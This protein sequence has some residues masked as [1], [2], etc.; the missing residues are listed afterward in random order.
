MKKKNALLSLAAAFLAL[1]GVFL[2]GCSPILESPEIRIIPGG[3]GLLSVSLSGPG[4]SASQSVRTMLALSPEF[5]A[6]ELTIS[7]DP[8]TVTGGATG[9]K[10][11]SSIAGSF[12]IELPAGE[13]TVSAAGYTGDKL[14]AKTGD[15]KAVEIITG[16]QEDIAL[17]LA[18]YM[19]DDVY[20]SLLY[21]LNWDS[22]G[23][24]PAR[25]ELLVER[26]DDSN[27]GWNA[28]PISLI[29][30][31]LTAGP[32]QGT[33]LLVRRETGL[34]QQTGSLTLPPGEYR[35]TTSVTM[36]GP[37]PPVSRTD[38]AHIFSNL[39]TPAAFVYGAG[40][41][42]V[43]GPGTDTGSGFITRFNFAETPGAVSVIGS[44]P[45]PDG[46]RLIMVMV[47]AA[48][49]L[50]HLTPVVEC[51]A[52]AQITSP[53]PLYDPAGTV[54]WPAGDYS[55]PTSW[56][57]EGRNGVTQQ[58]TVVVTEQAAGEGFIT[59]IAFEDVTVTSVV[60]DQANRSITVEVPNGTLAAHSNYELKPVISFTGSQ[61]TVVDPDYLN[62]PA[63][64]SPFTQGDP[65]E[66]IENGIP[67]R[68]FRVTGQNGET[69]AYTVMIL[70]ALS[71]DAEITRFFFDG[72]PDCPVTL[73]QPSGSPY[74]DGTIFVTLPYASNLSSLKPLITYKGKIEPA[75]GMEQNFNVPVK[76]I[77]T[78]EDRS[79]AKTYTV[80][81]NTEAANT[82]T[83]I[84]DFVITNVPRAKVVIGTKPRADGKI[85]IVVSVPY[86]TAPLITPTPDD[87]P[88]TDL[89]ALIPKITL[90]SSDSK[91]V[92]SG[93]SDMSPPNGTTD[94]IPFGNSNDDYQEA[95]YRI[96]AQAGNIQDYVVVAA[97]DVHYYYV[98]ATGDDTDPDQYNGG[99]ES[100]PFK[101]LAYA[102]YQA[103][104]HNVDH[105]YVIGTLNDASEGG[106]WENTASTAMGGSGDFHQSGAPSVAGG[107]SVFNLNGAGRDGAA[108]WRLS[109]TGVGSN[110]VLQGA[111]GKRVIAVTGG[112]H[113]T[114]ENITIRGGGGTA[115][116]K[117]GGMYIGGG[118]TVI[119][120]S[121]GIT[122]NK[123]LSGG[124]VY[125]DDGE[126]DLITGSVSGNTAA[127]NAV[128]RSDF[129]NNTIGTASIQGGGGVYVNGDSILWLFNGEIA[130]NT[131]SGSGGG[132]LVNAS[133]IPNNP[134]LDTTPHNFLMSGG[135]VNGNTSTGAV[136]PHG[137]GGVFVAKGVFEMLNGNIMSNKS[138]RQ[139][140]GVFVWSRALFYMDGDSS[141]TGNSG[142]GS[143]KA[144]CSRGITTMR[145]KA[146]ADKVYVWNYAK[147]SWNNGFGDEFT[148]MEG[149]RVSGLVLAFA[150]DPQDNRN[151]LNILQ[152]DRSGQFFT[153][154]TDPIT[155]I[156]LESRLNANGSFS[157]AAT[158]SGD[159]EG[160]YLIKNGGNVVPPDVIKRFPLGSFTSGNPSAS[161]SASYK[162]DGQGRLVHK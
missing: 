97:R 43:T 60:I 131:T 7:P 57:A 119:W 113:I 28:I 23:Q 134:A 115:Y 143:S 149:A 36:D 137:G 100:I 156:D 83:G 2:G 162:L 135:S 62:D 116:E 17:T 80:T 32:Q 124:G 26:H 96:K 19:D 65:L 94:I 6:Y 88:K 46:T 138:T 41:L 13:Y 81:V 71:S 79:V 98:K 10:T 147:G 109:I 73:T 85:P 136:W 58:Y 122:G 92:D 148:L 51:A 84:F 78:S 48:A 111:A 144:I 12:Q 29:N 52:G 129:E 8:E 142:V 150:D 118:S 35:L 30:E 63:H 4:A 21:S 157:T 82:D 153:G 75:S 95:V 154:G 11:Y 155:T 38:I 20:G 127:G 24:I 105:I 112:A 140:G 50:T 146:Q 77:V 39:T 106:A 68:I 123:A 37:N 64:D 61:V 53:P 15:D 104:K 56:I 54:S 1:A 16:T 159:W 66:F 91:F 152:S 34:V 59:A 139:G 27:D 141:V 117:G 69:K 25:A 47:P 120:K 103:V 99:S 31:T 74:D 145:G 107:P 130:N 126:F 70:E 40:D 161:L 5:T 102:V 93:G 110:A 114:F 125:V 108:A 67:A 160:K 151:Y 121:G 3:M 128:A 22:A 87:G 133:V 18:P 89:K 158:I 55:R 49:V 72:Y 9:S 33:I 44:N 14:T 86:A 132:V 45:G 76:Y 42:T 90:S 101:T